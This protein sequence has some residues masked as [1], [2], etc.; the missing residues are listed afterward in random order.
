MGIFTQIILHTQGTHKSFAKYLA[1]A[2]SLVLLT[3][4]AIVQI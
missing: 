2:D 1:K 3:K 4:Q